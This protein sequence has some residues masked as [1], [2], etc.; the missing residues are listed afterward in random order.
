KLRFTQVGSRNIDGYRGIAVSRIE[1]LAELECL[2]DDPTGQWFYQPGALGHG[3][4]FIRR[5]KPVLRV[6]PANQRFEAGNPGAFEVNLGLE[7]QVE[8]VVL[9]G[10]AEVAHQREPAG[11]VRIHF[12]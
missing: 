8:T 5:H 12:R 9:N 10:F 11:V 1:R 2:T 3:D 6:V 4:E 7:V